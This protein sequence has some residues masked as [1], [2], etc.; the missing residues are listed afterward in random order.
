MSVLR[1]EPIVGA[2]NH[3]V[4]LLCV[5]TLAFLILAVFLISE[6]RAVWGGTLGGQA[7]MRVLNIVLVS[8][9]PC[10]SEKVLSHRAFEN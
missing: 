10:G 9:L 2:L 8:L 4:T 3:S 5:H 1:P 6:R 7:Y